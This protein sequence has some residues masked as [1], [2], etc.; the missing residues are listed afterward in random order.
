MSQ[1]IT[2]VWRRPSGPA[3]SPIFTERISILSRLHALPAPQRPGQLQADTPLGRLTLQG[4][5]ERG[6]LLEACAARR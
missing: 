4:V 5:P 2:Y 3:P 1:S 6:L